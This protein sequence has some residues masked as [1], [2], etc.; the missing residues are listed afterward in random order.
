MDGEVAGAAC[1]AGDQYGLGALRCRGA[2]RGE[3]HLPAAHQRHRLH[4]AS[5]VR[6][7]ARQE[8][9]REGEFGVGAGERERG[10]AVAEGE[11][12]DVR[13]EP[14]DRTGDLAAG[15]RGQRIAAALAVAAH[16]SDARQRDADR[17]RTHQQFTGA[18]HRRL[19]LLDAQDLGAAIG[20]ESNAAHG[21]TPPGS[22]VGARCAVRGA[23]CAVR[24]APAGDRL[25]GR[26]WRPPTRFHWVPQR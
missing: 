3:C 9:G 26:R 17:L 20:M 19:G 5:T 25:C 13:A 7:P 14:D 8:G 11:A 15:H 18:G 1:R 4:R 2:E 16:P 22:S 21:P 23:R 6:Y 24:G 10:D 12:G